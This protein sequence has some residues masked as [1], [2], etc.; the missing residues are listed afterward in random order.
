[1]LTDSARVQKPVLGRKHLVLGLDFGTAFTRVVIGDNR[2]RYAV[3][4]AEFAP[5]GNPYLLP[6]ILDIHYNFCSLSPAC[7]HDCRENLKLPLIEKSY[8][9]D[10]LLRISAYLALVFRASREWLLSRYQD[11]YGHF[12][13][14]WTVNAGIPADIG[15][16]DDNAKL[17]AIY[18]RVIHAAWNISVLPGPI[19]LNR[20]RQY[21]GVDNGAFAAFPAVYRTMLMSRDDI[22]IFSGCC[23]QIC[24]YVN[25]PKC[26]F[27]LHMLIDVGAGT[28]NIATFAIEKASDSKSRN[29]CLLYA[30]AIEP[31]GVSNM[32]DRR[33]DNLKLSDREIN[34]FRD[35]PDLETFSQ[36]HGI[37]EKEVRFADALY[38]GDVARL[39]NRVLDETRKHCP[40]SPAWEGGVP[41]FVYGGGARLEIVRSI[42]HSHENKSP[43]HRIRAIWLNPPD[44]LLAEHLPRNAFDRLSMAY[45]LSF[46]PEE[47][48]SALPGSSVPPQAVDHIVHDSMA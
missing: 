19:T 18:K 30:C 28:V 7:E 43:P 15:K 20:V 37:S 9:E 32:L 33:Y 39:I 23:G 26:D 2:V 22:N 25:S 12:S 36:K 16:S 6:S 40:D 14:S 5:A 21:M 27:D 11:R 34:L 3:P 24:G 45:G 1:M 13:L 48:R 38:R 41:T 44:D 31:L 17:S 8:T 10:D 35:I 42:V 47:I 29:S 4:F 46:R